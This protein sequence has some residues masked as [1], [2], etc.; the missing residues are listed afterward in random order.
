MD[1][2]KQLLQ[3]TSKSHYNHYCN[4]LRL[5]MLEACFQIYLRPWEYP[6]DKR[7]EHVSKGPKREHIRFV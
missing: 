4:Y 5:K 7:K 3:M 6:G 1:Y 2:D